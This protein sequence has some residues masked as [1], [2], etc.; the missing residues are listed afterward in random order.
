MIG[1]NKSVL[2]VGCSTGYFTKILAERGCS[3]V[4]IEIDCDAARTAEQW[5][6][7][8]IVGNI[9]DGGVWDEV[10]D[11]SFDVVVL[12]DVLEHLRD[13]LGSLRQ[14]AGKLKPSGSVV[15]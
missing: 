12:G 11:E 6:D 10:K 14:A 13:P 1:Y 3:V 5:A 4:G 2:E 15:T 9:D 7:R 8:V